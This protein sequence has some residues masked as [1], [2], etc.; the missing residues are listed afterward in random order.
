MDTRRASPL[1]RKLSLKVLATL[2]ASAALF[3]ALP[4]AAAQ[5]EGRFDPYTQG[6]STDKADP[7]TQG[8]DRHADTYGY[9]AWK[10][11]RFDPYSQGTDRQASAY[12]V[13]AWRWDT[14][15]PGDAQGH[16]A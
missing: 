8:L 12:D 3:T 5:S 9:L 11:D 14:S 10:Y 13:L 7:Y 15:Y 6:A 2:C 1:S 16:R 4:A